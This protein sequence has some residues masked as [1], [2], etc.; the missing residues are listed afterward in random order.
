MSDMNNVIETTVKAAVVAALAST[1][2]DILSRLVEQILTKEVNQHGNTKIDYSDKKLKYIDFLFQDQL[3]NIIRTA[4]QEYIKE[5]HETIKDAVKNKLGEKDGFVDSL[6]AN[7]NQ[8]M[9][10]DWKL[11]VNIGTIEK[12][13]Y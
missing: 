3:S 7:V 5:N 2:D 8:T 1:K 11:N 4:V 9:E 6:V 10:A 12:S 13:R